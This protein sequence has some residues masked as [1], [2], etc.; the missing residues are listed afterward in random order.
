MLAPRNEAALHQMVDSQ[1]GRFHNS[2]GLGIAGDRDVDSDH[3]DSSGSAGPLS[4]EYVRGVD[5]H[6]GQKSKVY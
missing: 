2:T 3:V 6:D 1:I 4:I 5:S